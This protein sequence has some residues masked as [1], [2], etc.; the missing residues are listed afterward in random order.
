MRYTVL[1]RRCNNLKDDD[2]EIEALQAA[3][4]ILLQRRTEIQKDDL[5][6]ARYSALPFYNEL[7]KDVLYVGAKLLNS[8]QQH[9]Y[10]A[11]LQNW[12]VDLKE[13]TPLTWDRLDLL[14]EEGPF[15]LKG[16]T[17]SKKGNWKTHMY[18]SNKEEAIEVYFRLSNDSLIGEQPIYIRKFVPLY[19]YHY[20][21]AGMPVTKEF[22]FFICDQNVLCGAYYW[23]SHVEELTSLPSVTEVPDR[24]LQESI[25]RIAKNSNA[26]RAYVL[27]VGIQQNGSPIVIELND[28]QMAGLSENSPFLFYQNLKKQLEK[29]EESSIFC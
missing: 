17:N 16:G 11:D 6:V 21:V 25:A 24:F 28:L 13:M 19:T 22:R 7:E 4:F 5:V 2:L 20:D 8:Y 1:Y 3:G 15:I 29:T 18:A 23:S 26:P 12:V 14:P 10:I 9:S 27:D